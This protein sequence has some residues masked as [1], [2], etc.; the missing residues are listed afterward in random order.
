[1]E[2]PV[3]SEGFVPVVGDVDVVPVCEPEL[4]PEGLLEYVPLPV[5]E[6]LLLELVSCATTQVAP[7]SNSDK[8]VA[9]DFMVAAS[10]RGKSITVAV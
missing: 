2:L 10:L 3:W 9:F 5:W 6:E 1:M 4:D 8:T 7:S